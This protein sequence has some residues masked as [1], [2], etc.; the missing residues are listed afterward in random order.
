ML[1]DVASTI[2]ILRP[3]L[4]VAAF[5]GDPMNLPLWWGETVGVEPRESAAL[6]VGDHFVVVAAPI[7]G[8]RP[9]YEYVVADHV[10]GASLVLRSVDGPFPMEV[11]C[12]WSPVPNGS[13]RMT[14]RRACEPKG[15]R[16]L[17]HR[18]VAA[19]LASTNV[20]DLD[21]LRVA[22]CDGATADSSP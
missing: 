17:L 4:V 18:S 16:R 6:K 5:V 3:V 21:R 20:N 9:R 1:V 8:H 13:T 19:A 10:P 15:L 14:L 2:V 11:G 22:L 7:G 12:S